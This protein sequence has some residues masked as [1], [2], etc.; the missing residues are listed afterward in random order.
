M[1]DPIDRFPGFL[2]ARGRR[3]TRERE[4]VVRVLFT[5]SVLRSPEQVGRL[6]SAS[7]ISRASVFR[8]SIQLEGAELLP[9]SRARAMPGN[10]D[11]TIAGAFCDAHHSRPAFGTCRWCGCQIAD[12]K[13]DM[14]SG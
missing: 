9:G 5:Q 2:E 6:L 12:G 11:I 8:T 7:G 13:I 4:T 1:I 10:D 14:G 3:L